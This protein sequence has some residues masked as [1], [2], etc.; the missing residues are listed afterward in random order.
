MRVLGVSTTTHDKNSTG[1]IVLG[2]ALMLCKQA[3]HEVKYIDA[4]K[5]H[6]VKN[7]SCYS[8][9]GKH[10]ADPTS[11]PYRC[12]AHENSVKD[13]DKFGGVDEMPQIYDGL[14][15]ADAIVW[16]TSVRWMS[17]TALFQTIIERMNTLENRQ[18]VYNE[19]NPLK[20]K[21]T[22]VIVTGHHYMAQQVASRCLETLGFFGF[23]VNPE[24][25]FTWQRT[26]DMNHE[27]VGDNNKFIREHLDSTAGRIQL[28]NFLL[29]CEVNL[30]QG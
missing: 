29:S 4:N 15:W 26:L 1:R 6:I 17:H 22:G 5:L 21:T 30:G 20:G 12:W 8:E 27:Q 16:S 24:S 3:G 23:T 25:M 13:P 7:L 28:R 2:R 18:V 10:C 9:G 19:P 14:E 11:G